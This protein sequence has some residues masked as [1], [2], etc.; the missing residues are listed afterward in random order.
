MRICFTH[1][2]IQNLCFFIGVVCII[3][4]CRSKDEGILTIATAAN[5]QF[6][7]EEIAIEFT[8][9][10]SVKTQIIIAS[11]G[12]HTAQIKAG[13]PYDVFISADTKFPQMLYEQGL[14]VTEPAIYAFGTLVIW[15]FQDSLILDMPNLL[16]RN[17]EHIALPNPKTA[18]Y[19]FAANEALIFFNVYDSA[20]HKLIYGESVAQTNQF[21]I[22]RAVEIG[23]TSASSTM[24]AE[25]INKGRWQEVDRNSYS[26]I[27]QAAVVIS[28]SK[29]LLDAEKFYLFLF[30]AKAQA[31][32]QAHGYKILD[33]E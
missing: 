32:L 8:R 28:Q 22:S 26:P 4:S 1:K 17:I 21:I 24:A 10:T 14:T 27:A 9:K 2:S 5:A 6:A 12:K 7:M 20:S 30:S 16:S 33:L 18:P 23:F 31:I 29:H 19:G 11:S 13:A 25:M 3:S 15:S